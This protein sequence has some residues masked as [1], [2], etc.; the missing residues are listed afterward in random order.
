M[1][2]VVIK[3]LHVQFKGWGQSPWILLDPRLIAEVTELT[4][5]RMG[6]S[7]IKLPARFLHVTSLKSEIS[8]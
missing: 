5:F 3:T 4:L 2:D 1:Q 6:V 8:P 7:E